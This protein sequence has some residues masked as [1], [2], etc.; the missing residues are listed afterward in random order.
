MLDNLVLDDDS[1]LIEGGNKNELLKK[2]YK[3][4]WRD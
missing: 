3:N 2:I 4:M 1:E